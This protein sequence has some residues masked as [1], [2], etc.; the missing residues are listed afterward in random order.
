MS[1]P[2]TE[3]NPM[4][5]AVVDAL[6][7]SPDWTPLPRDVV[8][9]V[10]HRVVEREGAAKAHAAGHRKLLATLEQEAH[11]LEEVFVP[12]NR[13]AVLRNAAEACDLAGVMPQIEIVG[14]IDRAHAS[15][16]VAVEDNGPGIPEDVRERVFRP[17][18]TTRAE[19]TGLG[20]SIVQKLKAA[21]ALLA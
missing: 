4:Q 9:A 19:G 16:W 15:C 5:Q 1:T 20:L 21:H 3:L 18:F 11:D 13:D 17:F 2:P 8:E 7:K 6:G 12:P 14:R 10:R